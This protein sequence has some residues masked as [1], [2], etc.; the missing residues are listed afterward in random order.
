MS[1]LEIFLSYPRL[2]KDIAQHIREYLKDYYQ[3]FLDESSI[4][5]GEKWAKSIHDNI[6]RCDFLYL[7]L[8]AVH[9]EV[10]R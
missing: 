6:S 5:Q 8:Q 7:L 3:V 2:D 1:R 9:W 4:R 10:Q